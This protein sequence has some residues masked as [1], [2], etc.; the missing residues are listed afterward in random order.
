MRM[1]SVIVV[2]LVFLSAGNA[3]ASYEINGLFDAR[4]SGMGG[5][6]VAF[7]D[8]AGAIPT[9]PALLDQIGRLTLSVDGLL[10]AAQP[11]APYTISRLDASGQPY[12][13]YETIRSPPTLALLP[14]VGG[15]YRV[16]DRVVIG[17]AVYPV[18]GGGTSAKFHPA[19]DQFPQVEIVNK[20]A[21]GFVEVGVP[22]SVR[23]LDNLSVA[24]MW[25][26]SHMIQTASTAV[27]GNPPI[28]ALVDSDHNP[29]TAN[30][31]VAGTNFTGLQLGVLYKPL[32]FLRFGL[33]YRSKVV[34]EA[35]GN[36]TTKNPVGG[37]S[38]V[39][40]TSTEFANPHAIRAGLALSV[41][42]DKLLFAGDFKYLKYGDVK[43]ID[44]TTTMMKGNMPVS[45]TNQT[46]VYF[47]D[48]YTA[49]FGTEY[50]ASDMFR[51]RAGYILS[52]TAT[53]PEY[54]IQQLA[55]P[56]V[57][58]CVT[59]GL[60]IQPLAS[61]NVDLGFAYVVAQSRVETATNYNSGVGIYA[62]HTSE[63]G[64]S[65]TYHM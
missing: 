17:A 6:G 42:H 37:M 44:T 41:L 30:I 52:T 3:S 34:V 18:I 50:K 35:N 65:G 28:G 51:L 4:S 61:L 39:I 25:R 63:F 2:L 10:L 53:N 32:P 62:S 16:V 43:H 21:I 8:S 33:S 26:I 40:P 12:R 54:A 22:V 1:R 38:L 48:A 36:T 57:G 20:A 56:G 47:K 45:S 29:I 13:N 64:L 27:P 31:D 23:V 14:F 19:P 5:T 24:A 59:A 55:P 7:L 49:Q 60:G 15:A 46:P 9:N 58:H 11:E